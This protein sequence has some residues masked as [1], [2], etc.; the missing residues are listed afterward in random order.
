M[1][2]F[3]NTNRHFKGQQGDENIACFCRK[4]W[5]VLI[6]LFCGVAIFITIIL[7]I[8]AVLNPK[9]ILFLREQQTFLSVLL[10]LAAMLS[11][12]YINY[13]FIK[14]INYFLEVLVI[15]NYRVIE[16]R[17]TL[18]INHDRDAIDL[19]K[20]QDV[21]KKQ[22][23]L[24]KNILNYGEI[25]ITLSGSSISKILKYIPNPE[26]HFRKIYDLKR[27]YIVKR[28]LEKRDQG[29]NLPKNKNDSITEPQS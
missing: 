13:F 29:L 23:G 21:I 14:F 26:Y 24:I 17:K 4:H 16:L 20:M 2:N 12:F 22:N 8:S 9:I 18:Y 3:D 7:L 6:P 11:A 25:I 15:T 1:D 28:G 10:I 27:E 19:S 5:I